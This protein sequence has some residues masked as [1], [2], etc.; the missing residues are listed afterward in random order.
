[1]LRVWR[2]LA[3]SI[4]ALTMNCGSGIWS[5]AD[6]APCRVAF[7]PAGRTHRKRRSFNRAA[8]F[9]MASFASCYEAQG[10]EG[11]AGPGSCPA[12]TDVPCELLPMAR[13]RAAAAQDR[14]FIPV[15]RHAAL[16]DELL[17][18]KSYQPANP[19]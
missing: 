6:V 11:E 8:A 4:A 15:C 9:A 5:S 16:E 3:S 1:M 19:A 10:M 14:Q 17:N 18:C 7:E 13:L 12:T 2:G